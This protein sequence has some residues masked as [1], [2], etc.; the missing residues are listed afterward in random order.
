MNQMLTIMPTKYKYIL[1]NI[2][3]TEDVSCINFNKKNMY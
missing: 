3:S 1:S 2:K